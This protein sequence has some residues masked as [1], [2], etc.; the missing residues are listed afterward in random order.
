MCWIYISQIYVLTIYVSKLDVDYICPARFKYSCVDYIADF[1]FL[2]MYVLNIYIS[3]LCVDHIC[4]K[5]ACWLY[6]SRCFQI[7]MCWLYSWLSV[8]WIFVCWIHISQIYV[9]TI[10]VSNLLVDYICFALFGYLCVDYIADFLRYSQH[11]NIY[12]RRIHSYIVN[13]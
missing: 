9:L 10:Y 8:S 2:N 13:T 3:N 1:L 6:M 12:S 4:L 11:V 7:F 5:F